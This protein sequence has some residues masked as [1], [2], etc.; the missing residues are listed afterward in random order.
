MDIY[1]VNRLSSETQASR[2]LGTLRLLYP[3]HDSDGPDW[4][5]QVKSVIGLLRDLRRV[6][7][8]D[9]SSE[10]DKQAARESYESFEIKENLDT[11]PILEQMRTEAVNI[12]SKAANLAIRKAKEDAKTNQGSEKGYVPGTA[13]YFEE[14][15]RLL[16][17]YFGITATAN[18]RPTTPE[19]EIT[20][21]ISRCQPLM[22]L[23]DIVT[24]YSDENTVSLASEVSLPFNK[25][26][27]F[28][29]GNL[30]HDFKMTIIHK[31]IAKMTSE[32]R[33]HS[34]LMDH[35]SVLGNLGSI[36]S[37]YGEK[38]A[39]DSLR[40]A[41]ATVEQLHKDHS[42]AFTKEDVATLKRALDKVINSDLT[43]LISSTYE[44]S[45]KESWVAQQY[46]RV[47]VCASFTA[48]LRAAG[49]N[50]NAS[51]DYISNWKNYKDKD[52][53]SP[54]HSA[55]HADIT[56]DN[57]PDGF[58]GKFIMNLALLRGCQTHW[59]IKEEVAK[60][61]K[62]RRWDIKS[63]MLGWMCS[64][65]Y[66]KDTTGD[67][68]VT[69]KEHRRAPKINTSW[70]N[71]LF[72]VA[73]DMPFSDS[74]GGL[75]GAYLTYEQ[76]TA[77]ISIGCTAITTIRR[78]HD[79][80]FFGGVPGEIATGGHSVAIVGIT[81]GHSG[82]IIHDSSTV[83]SGGK[84][85]RKHAEHFYRKL[86]NTPFQDGDK[87]QSVVISRE[88]ITHAGSKG[89]SDG[90]RKRKGTDEYF[91]KALI[92][93]PKAKMGAFKDL[94][95]QPNGRK[96]KPKITEGQSRHVNNAKNLYASTGVENEIKRIVNLM[97]SRLSGKS[98]RIYTNDIK[99]KVEDL[100]V[101]F[102]PGTCKY[103][104]ME[105]ETAPVVQSTGGRTVQVS[106]R[107]TEVDIIDLAKLSIMFKVANRD[108]TLTSMLQLSRSIFD[109]K[110]NKRRIKYVH[111]YMHTKQIYK[112]LKEISGMKVAPRFDEPVRIDNDIL[113]GLGL[114][115]FVPY[116]MEIQTDPNRAQ[117]FTVQLTFN[118]VNLGN[119][120]A[121]TLMRKKNSTDVPIL[122]IASR[123]GHDEKLS[124]LSRQAQ[125]QS[126]ED[127]QMNLMDAISKMSVK[128]SLTEFVPIYVMSR[129]ERMISS[130]ES[131]AQD[132]D[133][134]IDTSD[135]FYILYANLEPETRRSIQDS[136]E[137]GRDFDSTWRRWSTTLT[138]ASGSYS[139][140]IPHAA[141]TLVKS[142]KGKSGK[143]GKVGAVATT[144][145]SLG[146][147][148]GGTILASTVGRV[149]KKKWTEGGPLR[150]ISLNIPTLVPSMMYSL[151]Q[152][153]LHA[154]RLGEEDKF[155]AEIA[156]GAN[157]LLAR[158]YEPEDST[159]LFRRRI[160]L[161]NP[162]KI[163]GDGR[164]VNPNKQYEEINELADSLVTGK[165]L[166]YDLREIIIDNYISGLHEKDQIDFELG[167]FDVGKIE[168]DFGLKELEVKLGKLVQEEV[169]GDSDNKT[170]YLDSPKPIDDFRMLLFA[171]AQ[172]NGISAGICERMHKLERP[173]GDP[174]TSG[175]YEDAAIRLL[176]R[177][178][179]RS[180]VIEVLKSLIIMTGLDLTAGSIMLGSSRTDLLNFA[181]KAGQSIR[182]YEEEETSE[183]FEEELDGMASTINNIVNNILDGG[184]SAKKHGV[185][186][187]KLLSGAFID[188]R[189]STSKIRHGFIDSMFILLQI[190]EHIATGRLTEIKLDERGFSSYIDN[191][192]RLNT[193]A[194]DIPE[195]F[196]T[197]GDIAKAIEPTAGTVVLDH[198][199]YIGV[200]AVKPWAS[201][202]FA[203]VFYLGTIVG[204]IFGSS[205]TGGTSIIVAVAS[206]ILFMSFIL[207]L[208]IVGIEKITSSVADIITGTA[209]L[210]ILSEWLAARLRDGADISTLV[211]MCHKTNI[212]SRHILTFNDD[213]IDPRDTTFVDYPLVIVNGKPLSPDF[214]IHK[215]GYTLAM[216]SKVKTVMSDMID[217]VDQTFNASKPEDYH[218]LLKSMINSMEDGVKQDLNETGEYLNQILLECYKNARY[219]NK[220]HNMSN[221]DKM[222]IAM[223]L[224][225]ISRIVSGA[226]FND[227]SRDFISIIVRYTETD[228]SS[229]TYGDIADQACF[230][231]RFNMDTG[232]GT[233]T[234]KEDGHNRGRLRTAEQDW[235][236]A[237]STSA[238]MLTAL[239]VAK[240]QG[241]EPQ[242][243]YLFTT[244]L[245]D[246]AT[247]LLQLDALSLS[248]FV[249]NQ[250][251][252]LQGLSI[253]RGLVRHNMEAVGD[254]GRALMKSQMNEMGT[255]SL[256]KAMKFRSGY[257]FP[258]IKVFFIEEDMETFYLFDD[259]YSYASIIS[260]SVHMDRT[261]AI[262][263]AI[264]KVTN[265]HG[266]LSNVM[267]DRLNME[268]NFT[269][270]PDEN[271][272][273][274][275]IM[276][277]PG[278]KI[279]IQAGNTPLLDENNTIFT[280]RISSVNYSEVVTIEAQSHGD[281]LLEDLAT[282]Q[283][284]L[285]GTSS[286][287]GQGAISAVSDA[288]KKKA[289]ELLLGVDGYM[290]PIT[291]IKDIITYVLTDLITVSTH[292]DDFSLGNSMSAE[293]EEG[294][295]ETT[296]NLRTAMYL[297]YVPEKSAEVVGR[298]GIDAN[299]T[300]NS[301]LYENIHIVGDTGD[302]RSAFFM[303]GEDHGNWLVS[304]ETAW[305]VLNEINL[306][307]PNNILT[308]RPFDTRGTLVWGDMK[309][310][311]RFRRGVDFDSLGA[312]LAIQKL[313]SMLDSTGS[314]LSEILMSLIG[315]T[316]IDTMSNL[317]P[318]YISTLSFISLIVYYAKEMYLA[319][320]GEE[321]LP[322]DQ[323]RSL[324][325]TDS[326][327]FIQDSIA[328]LMT[329]DEK[330]GEVSGK[331]GDVVRKYA[332]TADR[333]YL[334]KKKLKEIVTNMNS[335]RRVLSE[336]AR[337]DKYKEGIGNLE[338]GKYADEAFGGDDATGRRRAR[339]YLTLEYAAA[340]VINFMRKVTYPNSSS[341]K[342]I[343][344]LHMKMS[345][346]DLVRNDMKLQSPFNAVKL[347]HPT[348]DLDISALKERSMTGLAPTE[349]HTEATIPLHRT[350]KP[351][352]WKVY[353]TFFRNINVFPAANTS[354]R[355][356]V[357]SS[358]LSNLMKET[359]AG[360]IVLLG[361]PTIRE[362]DRILLWDE[363]RD[364]Y[365]IIGVRSHTFIMSQDEGCL[366]II[367]PDMVT[368]TMY[369]IYDSTADALMWA[370]GTVLTAGMFIL[371][372]A[373]FISVGRS[374][375]KGFRYRS[376]AKSLKT[377][378]KVSQ[379]TRF[380]GL[381]G[382]L[383]PKLR[384]LGRSFLDSK[385]ISKLKNWAKTKG[386]GSGYNLHFSQQPKIVETRHKIT[387]VCADITRKLEDTLIHNKKV[388]DSCVNI[389]NKLA[390]NP[391]GLQMNAETM[392]A[393]QIK[394]WQAT[395]GRLNKS[396][397]FNKSTGKARA[398]NFNPKEPLSNIE[399]ADIRRIYAE[400]LSFKMIEAVNQRRGKGV[401][402]LNIK[403]HKT[404]TDELLTGNGKTGSK[405]SEAII[406]EKLKGG[407]TVNHALSKMERQMLEKINDLNRAK[408]VDVTV[409]NT[410]Q[411]VRDSYEIASYVTFS[412]RGL[413]S[414][415]KRYANFLAGYSVAQ[416]GL[417][418]TKDLIEMWCVTTETQDNV[419]LS[420]IYFRGEPFLAGVDSMDKG[421]GRQMGMLDIMYAR[422]SDILTAGMD[423]FTT[424]MAESLNRY[425]QQEY[426]QRSRLGSNNPLTIIRTKTPY[427]SPS[428]KSVI[429]E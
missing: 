91:I 22:D 246:L 407:G 50:W 17:N 206:M 195:N 213:A 304:N 337:D 419:V 62:A 225:T 293:M 425:L 197:T 98:L 240:D 145:L 203:T 343:S 66:H 297:K 330:T 151:I 280:G 30:V 210:T 69:G 63:M 160:Q 388:T 27:K 199:V 176:E 229:R 231:F 29:P 248:R 207:D 405:A 28:I 346:R 427:I 339:M 18:D 75:Y 387:A 299:I 181:S 198:I 93:V 58:P 219:S 158:N 317:H 307:L 11:T 40:R 255:T 89:I 408:G 78:F 122:P 308:V 395:L 182:E 298:M 187:L 76:L 385:A 283:V 81:T 117:A 272:P 417:Q 37:V 167:P 222:D 423:S 183:T 244:T 209:S 57:V 59:A 429:E 314:K 180:H 271:S 410:Q 391:D 26:E 403:D 141:G 121:E 306:L 153:F 409:A 296:N 68:A 380:S 49:W 287:S 398:K 80:D 288:L 12:V 42:D 120:A 34:D 109:G 74:I 111:D 258:S 130:W 276:L 289:A 217:I 406:P 404:L 336:L 2:Y 20:D 364:F 186:S 356:M 381:L 31:D 358:V 6:E 90:S 116:N 175:N 415:V 392:E 416:W 215:A 384:Q 428:E 348:S 218:T 144:L 99:G 137:T 193:K 106:I 377:G 184:D 400:E 138:G 362:N 375:V 155:I 397:I 333:P 61:P 4:A 261:S 245:K 265:I 313:T 264:L 85:N 413:T 53:D 202:V 170:R 321:A 426:A 412:Y 196:V 52:G 45:G 323:G 201:N 382:T 331:A 273:I 79:N 190:V 378:E 328:W 104:P 389:V 418:N 124:R 136:L 126:D 169:F 128:F 227:Q 35:L 315:R 374:L 161:K 150:S 414:M 249:A 228:N 39:K 371:T 163:K 342:R 274:N 162:I 71:T 172:I 341:H 310:Y 286:I 3:G 94:L 390:K 174:A 157:R 165:E 284:K 361:D 232:K 97:I 152:D 230:V 302:E 96:Y 424:P 327:S 322:I 221:N 263:S 189:Y 43:A 1:D 131:M 253:L 370:L 105:G 23:M 354:V 349:V 376:M 325:P 365:G 123:L 191:L 369:N 275:A 135:P 83:K 237:K 329:I 84:G 129:I 295:E 5:I 278:A 401:K 277:R 54:Y 101:D 420:P 345:G 14:A 319:S 262:Q 335:S 252:T 200:T 185:A 148:I 70:E 48:A 234:M 164:S 279:K 24:G 372:A 363:N 239:E 16:G 38:S 368:K 254:S 224:E 100:S 102:T 194:F 250:W 318:K 243:L 422:F 55:L 8:D 367:E 173:L 41:K 311:Y 316:D 179:S 324:G 236:S 140:L 73:D 154:H 359:Y 134:P 147:G 19:L 233:L 171:A 386:I 168:V 402:S 241:Y 146:P 326:G 294:Y 300:A 112:T 226:L 47:C 192:S 156:G 177:K 238:S 205:V 51:T 216:F 65:D 32:M 291:R 67:Y 188:N 393:L 115:S 149:S 118:Y 332:S 357:I 256:F 110:D 10:Q 351:W 46:R 208:I 166:I 266:N 340:E 379:S 344:D 269:S 159:G 77:M 285:Y 247:R 394:A 312:V 103:I 235:T 72:E 383:N 301:Q 334:L 350:L 139:S 92:V 211:K 366:S 251:G 25:Y 125:V 242:A 13:G 108:E 212:W 309:G 399:S 270:A 204:G 360:N 281:V 290:R 107:L 396:G 64:K 305:D 56:K 259:L 88:H 127:N 352:A 60:N 303:I 82:I 220:S 268:S 355:S 347:S 119:R 132:S 114:T 282:D 7:N 320:A 338:I 292:L 9:T 133:G 44:V 373:S 15:G 113:N 36:I 257:M 353:S 86:D 87:L 21:N 143:L 223:S 33:K 178:A 421:D 214:F 267:A 142:L 411:M 260:V 95:E